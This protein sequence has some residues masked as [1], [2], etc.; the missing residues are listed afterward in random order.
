MKDKTKTEYE[1]LLD[2]LTKYFRTFG[3]ITDS[4]K[5]AIKPSP[6]PEH[7]DNKVY[8]IAFRELSGRSKFAKG[9]MENNII[10]RFYNKEKK[11]GG[12]VYRYLK[13]KLVEANKKTLYMAWTIAY[14]LKTKDGLF[15]TKTLDEINETAN[16]GYFAIKTENDTRTPYEFYYIPYNDI[17]T[18]RSLQGSILRDYRV[19]GCNSLSIVL[20]VSDNESF[21]FVKN[22]KLPFSH[23]I[24][25][26][27]LP[28]LY[29]TPRF[30]FVRKKVDA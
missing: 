9:K 3:I 19:A 18:L 29:G 10:G 24:A 22:A 15:P 13:D 21:E 14:M 25:Q 6:D 4:L 28:N 11:S 30:R 1:C 27:D 8:D 17:V 20:V 16:D 12:Y 26:I 2:Y 5:D 7:N 23:I